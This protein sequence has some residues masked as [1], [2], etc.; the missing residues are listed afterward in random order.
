MKVSII[1]PT[2]NKVDYLI[3]SLKS[4]CEQT[5]NKEDYEVVLVDDGSSMD[6]YKVYQTYLSYI[7]IKYI[8]IEHLGRAIARNIAIDHAEGELILFTDDDALCMPEFIQKHWEHYQK[9]G[10]S[11][12]LG[13]RKKVFWGKD[14]IK[15]LQVKS[16][17]DCMQFL[18]NSTIKEDTYETTTRSIFCGRKNCLFDI[19]WICC[20]TANMSIPK[21]C[22]LEIGKF[23]TIYQGWGIED[24]DLGYRLKKKGVDFYYDSNILNYHMEHPRDKQQMIADII[25]NMQV[26]YDQY[27]DFSIIEY[28]R[29]FK[30]DIG[31]QEL[32]LNTQKER[33]YILYSKQNI[34]NK[35]LKYFSK[36]FSNTTVG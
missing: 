19:V 3:L 27:G 10:E 21:N 29:F 25:R 32:V 31:I 8:R 28:W 14:T 23:E 11:I 30:G 26:F 7:N 18:D 5:M 17:I 4:I 34:E 33:E 35:K 16:D 6:V 2:Y 1:I 12:L 36:E 22:L 20:I 13:K 15:R 9:F 24:I